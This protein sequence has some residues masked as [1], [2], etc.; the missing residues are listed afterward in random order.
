MGNDP[1]DDDY[2]NYIDNSGSN[3]DDIILHS[4]DCSETE[5]M[6]LYDDGD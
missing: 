6:N 2:T 5:I 4:D 1:Y 3:D